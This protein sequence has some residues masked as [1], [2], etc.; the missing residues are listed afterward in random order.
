[1]IDLRNDL[2][3]FYDFYIVAKENSFSLA[4]V[5]N[6]ISQPNLS[7]NVKTLESKLKL[8]LLI[9]T[10]KGITLTNDGVSLYNKL[11]KIFG[12]FEINNLFLSEGIISGELRVGVKSG[13]VG[14]ELIKALNEYN[15]KYPNVKIKVIF[16]TSKLNEMLNSHEID[17]LIDYM[18][19]ITDFETEDLKK[20]VLSKSKTCFACSKEFYKKIKNEIKTI[21]DINKFNLII[22]FNSNL[23]FS[24]LELTTN[25]GIDLKPVMELSDPSFIAKLVS[26]SNYIGYFKVEEAKEHNLAVIKID[27]ELPLCNVGMI[28][29]ENSLN[30]TTKKFI[31]L[32]KK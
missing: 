21:E 1:M 24:L 5:K 17:L 26:N 29:Y 6:N 30:I 23:N 15:E 31:D 9:R 19:F 16:E 11:D 14:N 22:P 8:I 2:P 3:L 18:P 20:V 4:A 13:V 10:N 27:K 28:Y 25:L 32:F 12:N 7:R